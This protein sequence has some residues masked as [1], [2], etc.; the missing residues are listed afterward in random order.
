M[1]YVSLFLK[2]VRIRWRSQLEYPGAYVLGILAQWLSYGFQFVTMW[3]M[4]Q[5][6]GTLGGWLPMQVLFLYAMNLFAYA[7]GATFAFNV[8]RETPQMART[9]AFDDVLIK[10]LDSFVY[11]LSA[12]INVGYVSHLSLAVVAM[13]ISLNALGVALSFVQ[14]LWLLVV[15]LSGAVIHAS[16]MILSCVPSLF[17]VSDADW[18]FLYWGLRDFLDYP[19]S[20]FARPL[21]LLFTFV[22]PF[23]FIN[24]YPAQAFLGLRDTLGLPAAIQYLTPAV[25]LALAGL[26]VLAWRG[27]VN[28]YE[29]TGS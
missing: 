9:G 27:A 18:G 7:S 24:F 15:L 10:P 28:R 25:A 14:V 8:V 16:L 12:N 2:F 23:A 19:L 1:F 21:Q 11:M 20:V 5:A 17:V 22:L 6:F 26:T 29:S 3:I 4:V 13:V